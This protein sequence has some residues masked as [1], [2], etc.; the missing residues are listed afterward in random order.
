MDGDGI[1]TDST[2][3]LYF[4]TATAPSM[5]TP[6]VRTTA[7]PSSSSAPRARSWTTSRRRPGDAG[8]RQPRSRVGRSAPAAESERALSRTR[9]SAPARTGRSTSSTATTWATSTQSKTRSCSRWSTSSRTTRDRRR[10]LQ[11]T[12]LLQRIVYFARSGPSPGVSA[13]QRAARR[14]LRRQNRRR[15]TQTYA[16]G[17]RRNDVHLRQRQHERDPL[18]PSDQRS[19][20]R[21]SST[22]TTRPTW[23]MSSTTAT[24][25]GHETRSTPGSSSL[26]RWW[27]TERSS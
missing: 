17:A 26:S 3:N 13:D 27:R 11:L 10:Q 19:R 16:P 9:W 25:P 5:R 24:R 21:V 22:P 1:A 4:I 12:G 18:D 8:R 23:P 14:R 2:G 20:P 15:S 7:T 6:A